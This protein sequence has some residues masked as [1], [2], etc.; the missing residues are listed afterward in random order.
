MRHRITP[1]DSR[2]SSK[3]KLQAFGPSGLEIL[4]SQNHRRFKIRLSINGL[5]VV[6]G[7][8][9]IIGSYRDTLPDESILKSLRDWNAGQPVIRTRQ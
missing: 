5:R 3:T 8:L 1:A 6:H 7:Q 9:A 4:Q 2:K